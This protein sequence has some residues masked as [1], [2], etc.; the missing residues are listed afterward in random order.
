M[1]GDSISGN[2]DISVSEEATETK[3]VTSKAYSSIHD[4]EKNAAKN[5]PRFLKSNFRDVITAELNKDDYETMVIQAGS[6]DITNLNTKDKTWYSVSNSNLSKTFA[7]GS[8]KSLD[9]F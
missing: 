9:K 3:L 1:F 4:T 5:S 6:V 2:V 7:P 8:S